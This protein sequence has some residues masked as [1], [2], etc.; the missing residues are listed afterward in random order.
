[1]SA[2]RKITKKAEEKPRAGRKQQFWGDRLTEPPEMRNIEYCAGRDVA[3]RPMADEELIPFDLWQNRAHVLM[4]ARQQII[5]ADTVKSILQALDEFEAQV[6]SGTLKLNPAKEDVHTNIEHFVATQAGA[7][8]SGT[9]H[10]GRSRNDQTTTVVRLYIREQLL[11]FA[12]SVSTLVGE[13]LSRAEETINMP[14]AGFTHYQPA[15]ITTVGHWF[16]SYSQMLLR[17]SGRLLACYDRVNVS[18]LGAAASFGTSWPIDRDLTAKLMGFSEAQCNTL[19]CI[20]NRWEMEADAAAA[21]SFIITHL[22]IIAQDLIILSGAQLDIIKIADR[23]VTGSSIMPQK[24]NPDFAEVTRAKAALIQNMMTSLFAIA[25]GALSGYNRDTQWTKYIIMDIFHEAADAPA[26]FGGVFNT[27]QVDAERARESAASDF[28]DAVD[29]ADSLAQRSGLPFRQTY[30]IASKAVRLSEKRG[31]IDMKIVER[32]AKEAGANGIRF[33]NASP[34]DLV[35]RK[36][37]FGGPAPAA[38]RTNLLE[39]RNQ[40][41]KIAQAFRERRTKL[42][43]AQQELGLMRERIAGDNK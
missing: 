42:E 37:H 4:L 40:H 16:L 20:T 26:V 39:Q 2:K 28:V 35:S 13:I 21:V 8:V 10:T 31:N 36:S 12:S 34:L 15:S 18:P 25:R 7:E 33:E 1:M 41:G 17:D 11:R 19:D 5:S 3:S 27:L 22:S 30:E 6:Q 9:M 43:L 14:I 29:V 38:A 24:R 23:Y 32:L